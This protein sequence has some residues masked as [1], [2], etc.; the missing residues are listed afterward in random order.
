MPDELSGMSLHGDPLTDRAARNR[1][2]EQVIRVEPSALSNPLLLI[3]GDPFE[4][5]EL[6]QF[7]KR[8]KLK[9]YVVRPEEGLAHR[10]DPESWSEIVGLKSHPPIVV[11]G[12]TKWL[13][14]AFPALLA[15]EWCWKAPQSEGNKS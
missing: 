9:S 7:L 10:D 12:R 8:Y 6:A 2:A 15:D 14:L 1:V 11:L 4:A 13:C 3:G 5:R